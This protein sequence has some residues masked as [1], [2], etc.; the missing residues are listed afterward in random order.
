MLTWK[1]DHKIFAII[2]KNI[3]KIF[4]LKSYINSQLIVFEEYHDLIDVFKKQNADKLFSH[5]K[6]Y[7]IEINLKLK[8]NSEFWIF[9]HVMK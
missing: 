6:K 1:W 9:V 4:K 8:K 3:K 2:I 7:N 5:Q